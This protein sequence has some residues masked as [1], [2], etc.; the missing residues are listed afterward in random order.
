MIFK[1]FKAPLKMQPLIYDPMGNTSLPDS[2]AQRDLCSCLASQQNFF[3]RV[4]DE[5]SK[6]DTLKSNQLCPV[7]NTVGDFTSFK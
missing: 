7:E 4:S 5:K 1:S 2:R 3:Y 6:I